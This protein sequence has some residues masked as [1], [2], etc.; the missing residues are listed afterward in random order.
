MAVLDPV[1]VAGSVISKTTLHNFDNI[2][3]KDIMIGDTCII[4]KA[5]DV[6]P[7]VVKVLKE[8]RDGTQRKYV[9]PTSVQYVMKF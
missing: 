7:E 9:V 6:I 5:G 8:K 3:S 4:Q 2:E 1:K